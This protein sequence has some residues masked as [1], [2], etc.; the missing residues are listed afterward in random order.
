MIFSDATLHE[1]TQ[2]KPKTTE[3]LLAVSGV[4][5]HKLSHYGQHFLKTLNEFND[6]EEQSVQVES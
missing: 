1:M 2:A 4:G 6:L 5:Q 3:Q